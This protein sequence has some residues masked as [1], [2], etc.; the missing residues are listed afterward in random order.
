M[1]PLCQCTLGDKTP[2][3]HHI[4]GGIVLVDGSFQAQAPIP[5]RPRKRSKGSRPT[6]LLDKFRL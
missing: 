1:K 2:H 5:P 3:T 6:K 4:E